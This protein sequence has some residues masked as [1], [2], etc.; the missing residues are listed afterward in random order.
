MPS[1]NHHKQ[2]WQVG[3][4]NLEKNWNV[5]GSVKDSMLTG[6]SYCQKE[7][8]FRN[9]GKILFTTFEFSETQADQ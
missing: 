2:F 3:K 8:Y 5:C 7:D 9:S 1:F 4:C 6:K